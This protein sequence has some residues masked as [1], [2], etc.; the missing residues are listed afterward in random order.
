VD[1]EVVVMT[2]LTATN[3]V[4]AEAQ[5]SRYE[6]VTRTR[7]DELSRQLDRLEA[8]VNALLVAA[9]ASLVAAVVHGMNR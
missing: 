8:K 4:A 7:L 6:L 5:P 3:G 9:V 2:D 1:V